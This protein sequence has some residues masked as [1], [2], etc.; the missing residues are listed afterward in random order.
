MPHGDLPYF[1]HMLD[2]IERM[3]RYLEGVNLEE[4]EANEVLQDAVIRQLEILGEAA[5]RVDSEV[6][7]SSPEIPWSKVI[8]TRN[9]LVHGYLS[10]NLEIVWH[11]ATHH[12]PP[13][14]KDL[15]EAIRGLKN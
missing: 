9:R 10:V 1:Q 12:V 7:R 3:R 15:E 13:L 2:A 8:A 6:R 4:F 11:T 14:K 5:S